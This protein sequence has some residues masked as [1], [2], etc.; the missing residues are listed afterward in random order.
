MGT[1]NRF[2]TIRNLV[3]ISRYWA[4]DPIQVGGKNAKYRRY[5][6]QLAKRTLASA[7]G[8]RHVA[9]GYKVC[10]DTRGRPRIYDREIIGLHIYFRAYIL[11]QLV[12]VGSW[13][14]W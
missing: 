8:E 7:K 12:Q 5:R 13:S 9:M 1:R 3:L 6:V 4:G 2:G 11:K 14:G 10:C